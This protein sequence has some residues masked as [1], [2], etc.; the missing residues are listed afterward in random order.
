[1]YTPSTFRTYCIRRDMSYTCAL[2]LSMRWGLLGVILGYIIIGIANMVIGDP[3]I[4]D[5]LIINVGNREIPYTHIMPIDGWIAPL[6]LFVPISAYMFL[7]FA[8]EQLQI[9]R[10]RRSKNSWDIGAQA[11]PGYFFGICGMILVGGAGIAA[12]IFASVIC[13]AIVMLLALTIFKD[14]NWVRYR[15]LTQVLYIPLLTSLVMWTGLTLL[16]GPLASLAYAITTLATAAAVFGIF[17]LP[18]VV[19]SV[20][21]R[22]Q[23]QVSAA[24]RRTMLECNPRAPEKC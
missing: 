14:G 12:S 5:R 10:K 6:G 3:I 17:V 1:M 16:V 20:T 13:M 8:R 21:K 23:K 11:L 2:R 15:D 4:Y 9:R 24:F 7:G 18:L 22:Q 19:N